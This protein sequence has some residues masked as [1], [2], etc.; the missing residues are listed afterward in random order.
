MVGGKED[1]YHQKC[2]AADFFI[3]GVD[4]GRLIA[5]AYAQRPDRRPRLL[6]GPQLH[7]HRRA[8]PA[9]RLVAPGDLLGLLRPRRAETRLRIGRADF[10][11]P[12]ALGSAHRLSV[13]TPPFHGGERGSTPLGRASFP[14]LQ[15][16]QR[17]TPR[18]G[19]DTERVSPRPS[20]SG[21]DT[22]L[23]R[24][25]QGFDSPW[26]RQLPLEIGLSDAAPVQRT[27]ALTEHY[28]RLR[29]DK[30]ILDAPAPILV[31]GSA[32]LPAGRKG[33]G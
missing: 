28:P 23:S 21:Q 3:P 30:L 26:A 29:N 19:L 33:L 18:G 24:R 1:S 20:S 7:P 6:S 14:L 22:A 13:R 2:M 4:K 17:L 10:Y 8:Q 5:F 12:R 9:A 31:P 32:D 25:E 16:G 15:P 27:G 11:R